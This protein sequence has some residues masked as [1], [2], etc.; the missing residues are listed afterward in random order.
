MSEFKNYEN[1]NP[2]SYQGYSNEQQNNPAP[3]YSY[4]T[5]QN[6][7]DSDDLKTSSFTQNVTKTT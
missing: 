3:Y 1:N 2:Y 6:Q 4:Y 5:T 7:N